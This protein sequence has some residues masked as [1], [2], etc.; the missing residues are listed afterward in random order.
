MNKNSWNE[1]KKDSLPEGFVLVAN[2]EEGTEH[3]KLKVVGRL[4]TED[5]ECIYCQG[6]GCFE[7]HNP[8]HFINIDLH[9]LDSNT[10]LLDSNQYRLTLD[11]EHKR[12]IE[13]EKEIK[14]LGGLTR[15]FAKTMQG[16]EEELEVQLK[17][18]KKLA[19]KLESKDEEEQ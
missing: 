10:S 6:D 13:E 1:I 19:D 18:L 17:R 11:E 4:R 9:D 12:L 15:D 2:F 14:V 3:Y 8:T 16:R 7:L 5:G